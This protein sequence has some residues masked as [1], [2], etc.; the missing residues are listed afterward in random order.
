MA[1]KLK[2]T[3]H[4][5]ANIERGRTEVTI[6]RLISIALLLNMKAHVI[7]QLAEEVLNI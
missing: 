4:S 7:V 1:L 6:T 3:S 2:I 5:Y